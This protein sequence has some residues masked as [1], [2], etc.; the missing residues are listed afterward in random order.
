MHRRGVVGVKRFRASDETLIISLLIM[1]GTGSM[2]LWRIRV[3]CAVTSMRYCN[4]LWE[5]HR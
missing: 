2:G 4:R 3:N 5:V 1:I